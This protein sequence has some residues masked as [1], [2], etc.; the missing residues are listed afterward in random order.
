[1]LQNNR[2]YRALSL[3]FVVWTSCS[4]SGQA[5][6]SARERDGR[7]TLT[8][9]T[10]STAVQQDSLLT[11]AARAID[12]RHP[13]RASRLLAPRLAD[14][15]RRTPATVLL[16]AEAAAAWEG[17]REVERLLAGERWLDS[18]ANGRAH[19]LLAR[20]ALARSPR[21]RATDSVAAMHAQRAMQLTDN[22]NT[23]AVRQ[24]LHA[25]ALERLGAFDASAFAYRKS[26]EQLGDLSDWLLLRAA[27]VTTDEGDRARLLADVRTPLARARR[28]WAEADARLR[29][30]DTVNA[31]SSLLLAGDTIAS[32]RLRL[33]SASM[34]EVERAEQRSWLSRVLTSR[35][36]ST[37]ARESAAL[38]LTHFAPLSSGEHLA[39]ARS[40]AT[41]GSAERAITAFHAAFAMSAGTSHDRFALAS[42]L[43]RAGRDA[44]AAQ[45]FARVDAPRAL[46]AAAAYQRARSL[47]R[48]GQSAAAQ[49]LLQQVTTQYRDLADGSG[50]AL[51]LLG[52]LASDARRDAEARTF[53]KQLAQRYPSHAM[54]PTARFRAALMAYVAGDLRVAALEW[55]SLANAPSPGVETNA[56]LYWAGRAWQRLGRATDASA[57]WRQVADRDPRSYYAMLA[58]QRLGEQPYAPP[59]TREP[60][61]A[62]WRVDGR[63]AGRLADEAHTWLVRAEQLAQLGLDPEAVFERDALFRDANAALA[64]TPPTPRAQEPTG[65]PRAPA[66]A[67][68]MSMR[69]LAAAYAFSRAGFASR[70]ILLAERARALG[71]Q[72]TAE[73]WRLFYPILHEPVIAAEAARQRIDPALV[74]AVIRQESRFTPTALSPAGARGLMQLM[75]ATGRAL[76][77]TRQMAPWDD[78]MLYQPDVSIELGTMH[79][80][81]EL[82]RNVNPSYA[83]AAYN[84]GGSRLTRWRTLRGADDPEVFVERIP[85]VETRD[86]VRIVLRNQEFYRALYPLRRGGTQ[87][88]ENARTQLE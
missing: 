1:M 74:A 83:L 72:L 77:R 17:W 20:A 62:D 87:A 75:P 49:R 31:A 19:E 41:S 26:A 13:T 70:G 10:S 11:L 81:G 86:Y 7:L 29:I 25:R 22:A 51:Y 8:W 61:K 85:Y 57:R 73:D 40:D 21:T 36:G 48:S 3:M 55:D 47:L 60:R 67:D 33:P 43:S 15:A 6:D 42:V 45:Q 18:I 38:L 84:A 69:A 54:T 23:R 59:D 58:A 65:V 44:E 63:F 14:P 12:E 52:D 39:I 37:E 34:P 64:A 4:G 53:W 16:A 2:A 50:Q 82:R 78:V 5:V 32:L 79:L 88:D 35:P 28:L 9:I 30:G 80:A 76:A 71:A 66:S 46:A 56:S 24:V 27:A 68:T